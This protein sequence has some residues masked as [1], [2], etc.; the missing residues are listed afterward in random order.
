MMFKV[1]FLQYN[2]TFMYEY[3]HIFNFTRFCKGQPHQASAS[4]SA[5]TLVMAN[6]YFYL[7]RRHTFS[8]IDPKVNADSE[9]NADALITS[10]DRH[11]DCSIG[12]MNIF[13]DS[14]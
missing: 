8:R 2:I 12:S 7:Y 5:L 1:L 6:I 4:V 13:D 3:E 11:F 14:C 10:N 9:L